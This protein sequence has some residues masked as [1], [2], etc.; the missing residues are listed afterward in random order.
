MASKKNFRIRYI[1]ITAAAVFLFLTGLAFSGFGS[2]IA[3][4]LHLQL[5]PALLRC[6]TAFSLGALS[7]VLGIALA[8]VLF[9]RF[10]C[11]VFCPFGLLQD[12]IVFF[13]RRKGNSAPNFREVR[14]GIAGI[15]Y[16]M[17]ILGWSAPPGNSA[18]SSLFAGRRKQ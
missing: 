17:L 7:V 14:Y 15:T 8:T 13:C 16:G 18:Q 5:G 12:I 6:A 2:G 11:S 4:F 3:P 10:Y 9:G 1:R